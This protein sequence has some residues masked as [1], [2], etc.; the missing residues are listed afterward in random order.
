M[1]GYLPEKPSQKLT[2]PPYS[3]YLAFLSKLGFAKPQVRGGAKKGRARTPKK[4]RPK[5]PEKETPAENNQAGQGFIGQEVGPVPPLFRPFT[6]K[7]A[8]K[9]DRGQPGRGI[10]GLLCIYVS[11]N[12]RDKV[13]L[14][15]YPVHMSNK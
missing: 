1:R 11:M 5:K 7:N 14:I 10:F 2:K 6:C 4:R 15:Y 12:R 3:A 9:L 8:K 13:F